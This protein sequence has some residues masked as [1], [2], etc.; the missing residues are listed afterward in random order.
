LIEPAIHL[1]ENGFAITAREAASLNRF[2]RPEAYN[3]MPNAFQKGRMAKRAT[4]SG[5]PIWQT[6]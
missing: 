4:P 3:T 2:R 5:N 1:A 6:H